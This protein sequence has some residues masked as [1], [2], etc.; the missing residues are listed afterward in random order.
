MKAKLFLFFIVLTAASCSNN[1]KDTWFEDNTQGKE[2]FIVSSFKSVENDIFEINKVYGAFGT[3]EIPA[4][5]N[6]HFYV[7]PGYESMAKGVK[8]KYNIEAGNAKLVHINENEFIDIDIFNKKGDN[9]ILNYNYKF[10][11]YSANDVTIKFTFI[12]G[13]NTEFNLTETYKIE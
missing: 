12:N 2:R 11:A 4:V 10:I 9:I 8:M 6:F 1:E 7:T 5:L 3:A 13:L